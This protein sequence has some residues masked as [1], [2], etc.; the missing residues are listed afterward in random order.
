[1][2]ATELTKICNEFF[3]VYPMNDPEML[4]VV[5]LNEERGTILISDG[6]KLW[7]NVNIMHTMSLRQK[8]L[9]SLRQKTVQLSHEAQP[10]SSKIMLNL[11]R[12]NSQF[13]FDPV[14]SELL[15][16]EI[17]TIFSKLAARL[18]AC[19]RELKRINNVPNIDVT[20]QANIAEAVPKPPKLGAPGMS[21]M[22]PNVRKRK[23]PGGLKYEDS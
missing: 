11:T 23:V 4:H 17:Q 7:E 20:Q 21:V 13:F 14:S 9:A 1:M 3:E 10:G 2:D 8:V 19:T 15:A 6:L 22:K 12:M 5:F 16:G 18:F